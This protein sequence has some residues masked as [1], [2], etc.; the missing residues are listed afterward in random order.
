[1]YNPMPTAIIAFLSLIMI[2][3]M[4]VGIGQMS[5]C[6]DDK[7]REEGRREERDRITVE[8]KKNVAKE[9]ARRNEKVQQYKKKI[10]LRDKKLGTI[11]DEKERSEKI[12]NSW[13]N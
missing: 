4:I 12:F 11:S 9:Y 13:G 5:S 10:D 2:L 8:A 7:L 6:K 1:M 3:L